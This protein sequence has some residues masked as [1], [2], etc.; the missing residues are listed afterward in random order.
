M[1]HDPILKKAVEQ[2]VHNLSFPVFQAL[3]FAYMAE[4]RPDIQEIYRTLCKPNLDVVTPKEV[5][6]N[7]EGDSPPPTKRRRSSIAMLRNRRRHSRATAQMTITR[8]EQ[9][10]TMTMNVEAFL[11]FLQ[12]NQGMHQV[13]LEDASSLIRRYDCLPSTT[14]ND[15]ISLRGFTHFMLC[16]EASPPAH[17]TG[18]VDHNMT[19]PLSDYFIAS[20]H[21]TYLTGHQLHGDSSVNMYTL[22]SHHRWLGSVTRI[23]HHKL[24]YSGVTLWLPLCRTGLLGWRWWRTRHLPRLHSHL[25]NKL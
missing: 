9:E 2:E 24:T 5:C 20:S 10:K 18:R 7:C 21:N 23:I 11:S 15:H 22:V 8:S 17:T 13:T 14:S 4:Q 3:Y 12:N 6:A 25:Q 16:Q 19:H 1:Q